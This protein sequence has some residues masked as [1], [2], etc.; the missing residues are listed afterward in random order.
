M[1]PAW[2]RPAGSAK[3]LAAARLHRS[4]CRNEEETKMSEGISAAASS[5]RL[6]GG[7]S[8]RRRLRRGGSAIIA[9][10]VA[11]AWHVSAESLWMA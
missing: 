4:S 1:H 5:W 9:A 2:R 3:T 11:L 10:I 7:G 8:S 6:G